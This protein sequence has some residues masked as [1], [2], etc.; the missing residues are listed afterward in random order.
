MSNLQKLVA[1]NGYYKDDSSEF[2]G[3]LCAIGLDVL[4]ND[5]DIFY[6]FDDGI[7]IVGEHGDFVVTSV[8]HL[9]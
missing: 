1:I 6:Y 4:D 9:Q 5:N 8:T 3:Y 2:F 7:E